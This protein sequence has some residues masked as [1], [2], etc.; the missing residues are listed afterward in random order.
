VGDRER[1]V[2]SSLAGS[3]KAPAS[4]A[5]RA[6]RLDFLRFPLL[7]LLCPPFGL[8]VSCPISPQ[9][10]QDQRLWTRGRG[11]QDSLKP[12]G[13]RRGAVAPSRTSGADIYARLP[14]D[15]SDHPVLSWDR[16]V[17]HVLD[18]TTTSGSALPNLALQDQGRRLTP[19][20]A[21]GL[22]SAPSLRPSDGGRRPGGDVGWT[23]D[24][25]PRS[26]RQPDPRYVVTGVFCLRVVMDER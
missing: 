21:A 4:S 14:L 16:T 23:L 24:A 3:W 7:H 13:G 2:S 1:V 9:E 5:R 26:E 11:V 8:A 12:P 25:S 6:R 18:Q 15:P 22:P 10:T 20:P 19:A 17:Y